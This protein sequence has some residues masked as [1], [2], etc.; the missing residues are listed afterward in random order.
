MSYE[1]VA[2]EAAKLTFTEQLKL[3]ALLANLVNAGGHKEEAAPQPRTD[4]RDTYPKGFFD[5]F[6]SDPGLMQERKSLSATSNK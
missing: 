4:Y 6:G 5:L 2:K 3:I 1:A